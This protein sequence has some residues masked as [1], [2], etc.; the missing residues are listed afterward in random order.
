MKINDLLS[1]APGLRGFASM[2]DMDPLVEAGALQDAHVVDVRFDALAGVLGV[3]FELRQAL[4]LRAANTGVLVARGVRE[5]AWSAP[6]RDTPL[7]AWPV[8]SS[9]PTVS[10][11]RFGLRLVMWPHPGA[12]FTVNAESAAFFIGNAAGLSEAPPDYTEHDRMTVADQVATWDSLFE[13]VG[14]AFLDA[15]G[16]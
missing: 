1:M 5:W 12:E 15:G 7:A 2:P 3:I 6:A 13:P 10:D 8:E 9:V 11:H 16:R 4:Q 14:A